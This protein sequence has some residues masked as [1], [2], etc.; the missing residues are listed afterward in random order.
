MVSSVTVVNDGRNPDG[1]E[2]HSLDVVEVVFD[3]FESS[4]TV[5]AQ[6]AAGRL[7]FIITS[8]SIS[9][10]LVDRSLLPFLFVGAEGQK[11]TEGRD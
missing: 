10:E 7:G 5:V 11:H 4:P 6:V 3:P 9:E 8:E 1:I 2:A